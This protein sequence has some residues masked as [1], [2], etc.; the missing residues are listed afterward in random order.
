M[1]SWYARRLGLLALALLTLLLGGYT[2]AAAESPLVDAEVVY[3]RIDDNGFSPSEL[4]IRA[5]T[6]VVWVNQGQ[7]PHS[8]TAG[9]AAFDSGRLEPGWRFAHTFERPGYVRYFSRFAAADEANPRASIRIVSSA[10]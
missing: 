5:G 2:S 7:Q 4:T 9:S 6:T 3:V 1:N 8:A 10:R